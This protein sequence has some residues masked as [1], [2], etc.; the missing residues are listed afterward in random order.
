MSEE[1]QEEEEHRPVVLHAEEAEIDAGW[2]GRS[3]NDCWGR[4]AEFT[5]K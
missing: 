2:S 1:R 4:D 5:W 3:E